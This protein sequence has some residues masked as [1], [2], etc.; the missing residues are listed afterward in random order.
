MSLRLYLDEDASRWSVLDALRNRDIDV[1]TTSEAGMLQRSDRDQLLWATAAG[2]VIF[3]HN[4]KHFCALHAAF[5]STS[6]AHAGIIVCK[7]SVP[8]GDQIRRLC[9]VVNTYSAQ[10]M[11]NK[12]L[13]L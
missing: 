11:A 4:V 12:L 5:A 13:Y 6:E 3:T 8:I 10:E 9:V 1:A 2:R 7:Q